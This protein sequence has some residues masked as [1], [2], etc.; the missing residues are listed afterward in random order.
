MRQTSSQSVLEFRRY[1]YISLGSETGI[2]G[3]PVQS[4]TKGLPPGYHPSGRYLPLQG[5]SNTRRGQ[6][7]AR[8]HA[9]LPFRFSNPLES[10]NAYYDRI[11]Q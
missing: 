4:R 3:L 7:S 6:G 2:A 5:G 8:Q 11:S 9:V 10:L 1:E